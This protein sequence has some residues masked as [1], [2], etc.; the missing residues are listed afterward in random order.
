MKN[1]FIFSLTVFLTV[2]FA[3]VISYSANH[4]SR[5]IASFLKSYGW[6]VSKNPIETYD[7]TVPETFGD[8]YKNYNVLQIE[9]GLDLLPFA[10]KS[11]VRY[12]YRV[13]NY[14]K[15][16]DQEVRANVLVIDGMPVAGDICTVNLDGFMHSLNFPE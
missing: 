1:F 3:G 10:G 4:T 9:A 13:L 5:D 14:P 16:I 6:I 12:T 11:G 2:T 8:V 7:V 15:S